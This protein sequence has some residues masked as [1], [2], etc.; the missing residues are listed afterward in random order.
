LVFV[1]ALCAALAAGVS[2][3]WAAKRPENSFGVRVVRVM[4][5]AS[6]VEINPCASGACW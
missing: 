6:P 5:V 3:V 4:P 1:I 2:T